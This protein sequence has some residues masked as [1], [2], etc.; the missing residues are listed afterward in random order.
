MSAVDEPREPADGIVE[1]A[2]SGRSYRVYRQDGRLRHREALGSPG[3]ELLLGDYPLAYLVGSGRFARTYLVEDAGFLVESPL[4]WY[5]SLDKWDMSPGYDRPDHRSFHRTIGQDCL[6]CHAGDVQ[7]IKGNDQRL[8]LAEMAISCERCHGPGNL[9]AQHWSDGSGQMGAEE[10]RTIANPRRLPRELAEAVCHQCHLTSEVQIAVRGRSPQDFRPG[11]RWQ[12]FVINYGPEADSGEMTVTGHV[13]QL[14]A[15][16]CYQA[17]DTLTCLTCHP[18]HAALDSEQRR[19][20]FRAVCLSC[21]EPSTC[22]MPL[23]ERIAKNVDRC[24]DCHMPQSP[25]D[26]PHVA[27][28]HHRIGIHRPLTETIEVPPSNHS[29][30]PLLD[31]SYLP[32][33][34]RQ[35]ADGLALLQSYRDHPDAPESKT[36]LHA[37]GSLVRSAIEQGLLDAPLALAQAELAAA[38]G[39]R[40]AAQKWADQT[41]SIGGATMIERT[42]AMRLLVG[43]AMES[44]RTDEAVAHLELLTTL[45]RDPR[46][47]FLLGVCRQRQQD[48]NGA[49]AALE[50]VCQIDPAPPE[51]HELLAA[52]YLQIGQKEQAAAGLERAQTLRRAADS[53]RP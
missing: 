51:T 29:L 27:F 33:A 3:E 28:T 39:D 15:S 45:R 19:E 22:G 44:G 26:V 50:R 52:L 17:S 8:R 25:T 47:W 14:R 1:H 20:H 46:D 10:D 48:T 11:L 41:L 32:A 30:A 43:L 24:A 53:L 5:A 34:E 12:D 37:A 31:V 9:H 49:I 38:G 40:A 35:R 6:Y 13:A 16:R 23:P 36:R 42:S 18:A 7:P 4:T 21:H 2:A